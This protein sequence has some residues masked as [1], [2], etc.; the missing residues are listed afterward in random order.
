M[1]RNQTFFFLLFLLVP[2]LWNNC[3]Q[4]KV[5]DPAGL[6]QSTPTSPPAPTAT[7][8]VYYISQDIVGPREKERVDPIY[9]RTAY[10]LKKE[11]FIILSVIIT[12]EGTVTNIAVLHSAG[13]Q[14]DA[15]AIKAVEKWEYY[16]A[17][18]EGKPVA[19]YYNISF[20][21]SRQTNENHTKSAITD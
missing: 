12:A 3:D 2:F 20:N 5:T 11:G 4:P 19:V 13:P 15:A 10:D 14:L 6:S 18:L 21:F 16:P 8:S 17:T 9:P 1:I 7:P